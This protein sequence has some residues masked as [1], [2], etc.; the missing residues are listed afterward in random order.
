MCCYFKLEI[1]IPV[2]MTVSANLA[3]ACQTIRAD[4]VTT[5]RAIQSQP[6]K[7][8]EAIPIVDRNLNV[9]AQH[10]SKPGHG[11]F[12][13]L[14]S[15]PQSRIEAVAH[16]ITEEVDAKYCSTDNQAGENHQPGRRAHIFRRG[17]RKHASP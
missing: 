2:A 16:G 11:L 15:L 6:G 1:S 17:L 3:S 4:S 13:A 10:A 5:D 14:G 8:V 7:V 12:P 9:V